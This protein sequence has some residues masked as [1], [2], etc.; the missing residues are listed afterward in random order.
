MADWMACNTGGKFA[1]APTFGPDASL[2]LSSVLHFKDTWLD[3][4]EEEIELEFNAP[5]APQTV[6]A[7]V[8]RGNCGWLEDCP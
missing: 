8:G 1:I 4:F 2:V 3:R 7:M 6:P 5:G